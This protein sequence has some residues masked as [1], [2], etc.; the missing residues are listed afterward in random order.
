MKEDSYKEI[1]CEE[2]VMT[3][4]QNKEK[5]VVSLKIKIPKS[6]KWKRKRECVSMDHMSQTA[7]SEDNNAETVLKEERKLR[8]KR[9]LDDDFADVVDDEFPFDVENT[10][11][12]DIETAKE[13]INTL[14]NE[15]PG[16]RL[17]TKKKQ[18]V[19]A[20]NVSSALESSEIQKESPKRITEK[21]T[22]KKFKK[23][24]NTN[25]LAVKKNQEDGNEVGVNVKA[26][27]TY[28]CVVKA[29]RNKEEEV[30]NV[31]DSGMESHD[32][33]KQL[34]R[35]RQNLE[36]VRL[37]VELIQKREKMKLL[38]VCKC[39][40]NLTNLSIFYLFGDFLLV[41]LSAL[42]NFIVICSCYLYRTQWK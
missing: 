32:E 29:Q 3:E 18:V 30:E 17:R 40:S 24:L 34:Q 1:G 38:E 12:L 21:R 5:N 28:D 39:M 22:D 9:K 16:K 4:K 10:G 41:L 37:L 36:R 20:V 13:E 27:V 11:I 33:L 23:H 14:N 7:D 35:L 6:I 42:I 26:L 25:D 2:D 19:E 31:M 15:E 8:K